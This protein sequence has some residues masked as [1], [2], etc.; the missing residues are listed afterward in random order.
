MLEELTLINLSV[1][2]LSPL[3]EL[4]ALRKLTLRMI[5]AE[6]DL[7]SIGAIVQLRSFTIDN[8]ARDEAPVRLSTLQP[9]ASA[10]ALEE[11]T[12]RETTIEDGDLTPLLSLPSL[13][14]VHLNS[15]IGADVQV[16]RVA[17]PDLEIHHVAPNPQLNLLQEV[18]GGVTLR[19]PDSSLQQ[20]SIFQSLAP[21]LG[22]ATNYDAE[23]RIRS[24]V[25]KRDPELAKRLEWDTEA[26]AVGIYAGK[27]EDI[28][29]VAE[30]VNEAL[31]A[32]GGQQRK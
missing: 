30:I 16:L 27:E 25:K 15:T 9:L 23:R 18:V 1:A 7:A 21:A 10:L 17:R 20:W 6:I 22:L 14:K 4:A 19:R 26:G 3:R 8:S 28:R 24:S 32:E 12:L 31:A 11:L 29:A 5:D 2:D 13:R